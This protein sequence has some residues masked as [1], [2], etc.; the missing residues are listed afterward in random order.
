MNMKRTNFYYP[1][2][3]LDR[4]KQASEHLGVPVSEVIRRAIEEALQKMK[5]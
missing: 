4:L 2:K 5:L 3:M 1:V